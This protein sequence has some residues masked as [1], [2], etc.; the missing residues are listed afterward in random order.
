MFRFIC[1]VV[2]LLALG[3]TTPTL[4]VVAEPARAVIA[5]PNAS[6]VSAQSSSSR[7]VSCA[8]ALCEFYIVYD[9]YTNHLYVACRGECQDPTYVDCSVVISDNGDG[10]HTDICGCWDAS[11]TTYVGPAGTQCAGK[12]IVGPHGP[13]SG[14]CDRINCAGTCPSHPFDDPPYT[15]EP[16]CP[17]T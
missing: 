7:V 11:H 13:I 15:P 9:I 12:T 6:V 10:T 1:L 14:S 17:C 8:R 4:Q 16:L 3:V 2:P 5:V